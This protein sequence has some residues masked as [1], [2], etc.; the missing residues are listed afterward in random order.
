MRKVMRPTVRYVTD[1]RVTPP[2][3]RPFINVDEANDYMDA[4]ESDLRYL[5]E[6]QVTYGRAAND[7]WVCMSLRGYGSSVSG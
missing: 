7:Q 4:F 5:R 2:D 1:I 6:L 3:T